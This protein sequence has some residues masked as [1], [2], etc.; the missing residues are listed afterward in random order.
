MFECVL[1]CR[2]MDGVVWCGVLM[3]MLRS[4]LLLISHIR[5]VLGRGGAGEGRLY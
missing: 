2:W 1:Y 4:I 5:R 3:L